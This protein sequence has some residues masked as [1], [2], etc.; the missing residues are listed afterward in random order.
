M[1]G[2]EYEDV[3]DSTLLYLLKVLSYSPES[4]F[5]PEQL[6]VLAKVAGQCK[7]LENAQVA[8]N[9]LQKILKLDAQV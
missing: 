6:K 9:T 3:L 2:G 1:S 8:A 4:D 5:K 7:N